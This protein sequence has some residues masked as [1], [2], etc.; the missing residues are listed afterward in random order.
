MSAVD[1]LEKEAA[2][3]KR[4]TK[5]LIRYCSV[6]GLVLA[7]VLF[8]VW[9]IVSKGLANDE[10]KLALVLFTS[11]VSALLGYITGKSSK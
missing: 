4:H 2:V 5:E 9:I 6:S 8:C 11:I 10:G 7:A 1:I 3:K